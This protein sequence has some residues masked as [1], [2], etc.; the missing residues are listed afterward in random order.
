MSL[1]RYVAQPSAV[2]TE[3]IADGFMK[4]LKNRLALPIFQVI[5]TASRE[6]DVVRDGFVDVYNLKRN[7]NDYVASPR[8]LFGIGRAYGK[9]ALGLSKLPASKGPEEAPP[10]EIYS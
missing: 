1:S 9:R 2:G 5:Q 8:I 3:A 7:I 4:K 6:D 10:E